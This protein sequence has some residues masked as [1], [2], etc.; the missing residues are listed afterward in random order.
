VEG[1][2]EGG[3]DRTSFFVP[4]DVDDIISIYSRHFEEVAWVSQGCPA[5]M[6]MD[7]RH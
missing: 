3:A 2:I 4:T 5:D 1:R 7:G 6:A